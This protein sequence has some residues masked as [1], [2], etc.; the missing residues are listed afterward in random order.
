MK[1]SLKLKL[2][3]SVASLALLAGALSTTTYAW[4]TTNAEAK[5]SSVKVNAEATSDSIYLSLDGTHFSNSVAITA[6]KVKL[7]AV[8][9]NTNAYQK[10][11]GNDAAAWSA[12]TEGKVTSTD[13][14]SGTASEGAYLTFTIFF[15]TTATNASDI[16]F[17]STKTTFTNG[18]NNP[19]TL[20]ADYGNG[21][22]N[23]AGTVY[24]D[25]YL[26][27]ATR[28]AVTSYENGVEGA[29]AS[30]ALEFGT[31]TRA[32]Y[33]TKDAAH[34]AVDKGGA[35]VENNAAWN[36]YQAVMGTKTTTPV[37]DGAKDIADT[38]VVAAKA[39]SGNVYRADFTFYVEGWDADCMDAILGQ[40]VTMAL[41]FKL[42]ST[43][44]GE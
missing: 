10:Y 34:T 28:L 17:D 23:K 40:A 4:F 11:T 24:S 38:T 6:D 2:G 16:V 30:D 5:V 22:T 36:Y 43:S 19:F 27:N 39:T 29:T 25:G 33:N 7:T 20:L 42:A 31:A 26:V 14:V 44:T 35:V 8:S 41:S 9:Y 15:K 18:E 3:M 37:A 32:V 1:K 13:G 12:A 21:T